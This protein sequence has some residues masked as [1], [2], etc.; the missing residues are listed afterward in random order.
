MREGL[1]LECP[2]VSCLVIIILFFFD[3]PQSLGEHV[4]NKKMNKGSGEKVNR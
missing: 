1:S 3:T 2:M 4:L